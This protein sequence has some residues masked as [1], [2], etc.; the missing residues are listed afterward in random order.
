[1]DGPC[2]LITA[3]NPKWLVVDVDDDLPRFPEIKAHGTHAIGFRYTDHEKG[4]ALRIQSFIVLSSDGFPFG[5]YG[6]PN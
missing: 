2:R 5:D 1:M 6:D 4:I 3:G